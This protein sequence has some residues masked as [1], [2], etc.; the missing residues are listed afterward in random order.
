MNPSLPH[1]LF[2]HLTVIIRGPV[3]QA[4]HA[5]QCYDQNQ[6]TKIITL[7]QPYDIE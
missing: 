3:E 5:E 7:K 4:L 1:Q 2:E 6:N